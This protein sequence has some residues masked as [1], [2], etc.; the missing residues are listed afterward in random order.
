MT[1]KCELHGGY[2][3]RCKQC[4]GTS[5]CKH[6]RYR[7]RCRACKGQG[8]CAHGCERYRCP[9]CR[10]LHT[11]VGVGAWC[12]GCL[13]TR[14]RQ[15]KVAGRRQQRRLCASCDPQTTPRL[16]HQLRSTILA[17]C[18]FPPSATDNVYVGTCNGADGVQRRRRPDMAWVLPPPSTLVVYLEIDEHGHRRYDP[19]CELAKIDE[20]NWGLEG[21]QKPPSLFIRYNP[22]QSRVSVDMLVEY[23][24][25]PVLGHA[26]ELVYSRCLD[27]I[28]ANV[29][30]VGYDNDCNILA[31]TDDKASGAL[32]VLKL[33]ACF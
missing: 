20:T 14:I 10:P 4:K 21:P 2:K 30:F 15:D 23:V 1:V 8:I 28:Q 22:H 7:Y 13:V 9:D 6:D 5:V 24:L 3:Y 19:V 31:T 12:Q 33:P 18:L 25:N 27:D 29:M 26:D 16:E 11:R 17:R 32:R